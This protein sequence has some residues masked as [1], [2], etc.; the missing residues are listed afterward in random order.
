[1]V[2]VMGERSP[3][4]FSRAVRGSSARA[5]LELVI[6]AATEIAPLGVLPSNFGAAGMTVP[7]L[8]A[9]TWVSRADWWSEPS[10]GARCRNC[11][12]LDL[13]RINPLFGS[14]DGLIERIC[15]ARCEC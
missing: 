2:P 11:A 10:G 4:W 12:Y 1:M 5:L 8:E 9:M 3:R 14:I 15:A 7:F 13:P 6:G